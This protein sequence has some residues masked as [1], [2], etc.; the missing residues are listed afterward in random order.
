MAQLEDTNGGFDY[1]ST[2]N[3][4]GGTDQEVIDLPYLPNGYTLQLTPTGGT[5][6]VQASLDAVDW[7]DW[8]ESLVQVTAA[9]FMHHMRYIRVVHDTA[10][11]SKLVVWGKRNG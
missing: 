1:E 6:K 8:N 11:A 5:A 7:I 10:T 2:F 9:T 4:T 3:Y